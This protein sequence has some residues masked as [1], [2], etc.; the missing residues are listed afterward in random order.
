MTPHRVH[1]ISTTWCKEISRL[2][3][4]TSLCGVS[5]NIP[6]KSKTDALPPG[7]LNHFG[8]FFSTDPRRGAETL[9]DP[10]PA[11]DE[12]ALLSKSGGFGRS[13]ACAKTLGS[14]GAGTDASIAQG[15][16]SQRDCR[17]GNIVRLSDSS[18][19]RRRRTDAGA[20]CS[21]ASV[22]SRTLGSDTLRSR[23]GGL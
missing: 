4:V 1:S 17:T 10:D 15:V 11:F 22:R 2:Y 12:L 20:S 19:N 3:V 8:T 23:R 6:V 13:S 18:S 14:S 16:I 5:C 9:P 7:T 21:C